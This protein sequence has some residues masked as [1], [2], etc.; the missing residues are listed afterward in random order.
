ML[1]F[2]DQLHQT[3]VVK[4]SQIMWRGEARRGEAR[5]GEAR[6][7]EARGGSGLFS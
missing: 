7:G 3:F 6:R 4:E 5:R 1:T 2:I